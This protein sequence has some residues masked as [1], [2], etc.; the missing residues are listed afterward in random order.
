MIDVRLIHDVLNIQDAYQ[1]AVSED[2]GAV[3]MFIGT[4][5]NYF[6]ELRV[7]TFV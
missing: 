2:C 3:S 1:K 5:R 7:G 4:T 6:G